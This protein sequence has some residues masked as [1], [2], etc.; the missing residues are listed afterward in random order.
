MPRPIR[1][2]PQLAHAIEDT[3]EGEALVWRVQCCSATQAAGHFR[4]VEAEQALQDHLVEVAPPPGQACREPRKHR[5]QPHD[6][7]P[8][9]AD[10]LP[11]PGMEDPAL[12]AEPST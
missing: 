5:C 6:H 7:C 1:H 11:L 2:R 10:Q 8:L 4:V 3:P 9:C 12:V